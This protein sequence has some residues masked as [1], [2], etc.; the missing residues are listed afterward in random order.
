MLFKCGITLEKEIIIAIIAAISVIVVAIIGLK[1]PHV[2]G[3][4]REVLILP[5]QGLGKTNHLKEK[6][7]STLV[8]RY[9]EEKLA[10]APPRAWRGGWDITLD[11][12]IDDFVSHTKKN[13]AYV[14]KIA[15]VSLGKAFDEKYCKSN[16]KYDVR[17]VYYSDWTEAFNFIINKKVM[18]DIKTLKTL[19]VGIGNGVAEKELY[20]S[21][22]DLTIVDIAPESLKNATEILSPKAAYNLNA[23]NLNCINDSSM[24]AYVSLTTYQ[25]AYFNVEKSLEEAKRVLENNGVIVISVICGNIGE[26]RYIE[27]QFDIKTGGYDRNRPF[28]LSYDIIRKLILLNFT[29]IGTCS[30]PSE[31]FVYG[32]KTLCRDGIEV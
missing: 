12:L 27:G 15:E 22:T 14:R 25:S 16:Y 30:T 23:S 24:G 2:S 17:G 9:M 11:V 10:I 21:I 28:E 26:N 32:E 18:R 5:E 29:N 13:K 20:K 8:P 6:H 7:I 3:G 4:G 31:I 1:K 19:V